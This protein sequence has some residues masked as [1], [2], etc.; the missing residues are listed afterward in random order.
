METEKPRYDKDSQ[1]VLDMFPPDFDWP[2]DSLV[3]PCLDQA[4]EHR[5]AVGVEPE[6]PYIVALPD[7]ATVDGAEVRG[8]HGARITLSL[9]WGDELIRGLYTETVFRTYEEI[10]AGIIYA[11]PWVG[12]ASRGELGSNEYSFVRDTDLI[13]VEAVAPETLAAE[14]ETYVLLAFIVHSFRWGDP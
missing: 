10:R 6:R 12:F 3:R 2:S 8:K 1:R 9:R 11:K 4:V 7:W 13:S 5:V 14:M